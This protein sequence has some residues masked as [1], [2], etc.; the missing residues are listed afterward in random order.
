MKFI[1]QGHWKEK[2]KKFKISY[3]VDSKVVEL[4]NLLISF[5]ISPIKKLSSISKSLYEIIV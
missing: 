5:Y 2:K 4:P 1:L 3:V